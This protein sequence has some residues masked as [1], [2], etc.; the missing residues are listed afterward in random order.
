MRYGNIVKT[1]QT[2][3]INNIFET[4]SFT[5]AYNHSVHAFMDITNWSPDNVSCI[6][7]SIIIRMPM[8][9]TRFYVILFLAAK[10]RSNKK[11]AAQVIIIV[12]FGKNDVLRSL[13]FVP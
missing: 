9:N 4:L 6:V 13:S 8:T 12:S 7:F 10:Q 2:T 3:A 5:I 1:A 11:I